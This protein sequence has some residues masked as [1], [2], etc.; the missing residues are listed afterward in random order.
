MENETKKP[1]ETSIE[2]SPPL[3]RQQS[4]L[5]D[6]FR[7][8]QKQPKTFTVHCCFFKLE[9]NFIKIFAMVAMVLNTI[10]F[11]ILLGLLI[12]SENS[13]MNEDIDLLATRAKVSTYTAY[14]QAYTLVAAYSGNEGYLAYYNNYSKVNDELT[15]NMLQKIPQS[16]SQQY[17]NNLQGIVNYLTDTDSQ[18]V[19]NIRDGNFTEAVRLLTSATYIARRN[20]FRT[21]QDVVLDYVLASQEQVSKITNAMSI[22][23]L[24]IICLA[25]VVTVPV[26]IFVFG[27]A[28]RSDSNNV[29][30]LREALAVDISHTMNND[31]LRNL[32]KNHCKKE[33]NSENFEFLE[34]VQQYKRLC[35]YQIE[36]VQTLSEETESSNSLGSV[37][38]ELSEV[39]NN[40][41]PST[42]SVVD[43]SSKSN[44]SLSVGQ[45]TTKRKKNLSTTQELETELEVVEAKKFQ[46]AQE[47]YEEFLNVNGPKSVNIDKKSTHDVLFQ[48]EL[49]KNRQIS[50]L[51]DDLFDFLEKEI[52]IV[53]LDSH[54]RFK[55][56][57]EFLKEMRVKKIHGLVMKHQNSQ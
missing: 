21:A 50:S 20:T 28:I 30:K 29:Q 13:Q 54:Y 53:M 45:P 44:T 3:K 11:L 27:L 26:I 5:D 47:I 1:I 10:T 31:R 22:T 38:F 49:Y 32:F 15:E 55:L 52:E 43:Q 19:S 40:A 2:S 34:K 18:A 12:Y 7:K 57:M 56:S 51:P 33:F 6:S 25:V 14:I 8:H 37:S 36:L 35:E 42:I 24:S 17:R 46:L 23:S 16:I 41:T 9:L 39:S 48:I 4:S